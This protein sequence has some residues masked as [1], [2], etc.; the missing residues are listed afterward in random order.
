[1]LRDIA[2]SLLKRSGPTF[3]D[4]DTARIELRAYR[5]NNNLNVHMISS[6]GDGQV[7]SSLIATG[8]SEREAKR[9]LQQAGETLSESLMSGQA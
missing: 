7:S 5:V 9:A 8:L 3:L 2:R 1:M 6:T 4:D